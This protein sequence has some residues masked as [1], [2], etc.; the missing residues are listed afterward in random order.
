[1]PIPREYMS[2]LVV[3]HLQCILTMK[4]FF[5]MSKSLS[6]R[7][8]YTR[9][10]LLKGITYLAIALNLTAGTVALP[11]LQASLLHAGLISLIAFL[12]AVE[13]LRVSSH[14]QQKPFSAL[15]LHHRLLYILG[16]LLALAELMAVP[17]IALFIYALGH[18]DLTY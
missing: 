6:T 4:V 7:K 15:A 11:Y 12:A 17:L 1:M 3:K 16:L 8:P 18:A 5:L 14:L 2:R 10:P 9:N 13:L